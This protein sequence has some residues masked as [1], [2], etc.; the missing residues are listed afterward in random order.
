MSILTIGTDQFVKMMK[1]PLHDYI[2]SLFKESLA[3][4][5]QGCVDRA[6][7]ETMKELPKAIKVRVQSMYQMQF[8]ETTINVQV[9]LRDKQKEQQTK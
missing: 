6:Y 1:D 7:A 5:M 8:D 2:Y 9:D 4:E 3:K